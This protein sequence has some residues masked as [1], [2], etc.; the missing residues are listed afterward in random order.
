MKGLQTKLKQITKD[1]TKA[2]ISVGI[3]EPDN[4]ISIGNHAL[5]FNATGDF[6][7]GIP[8]RRSVLFWGESGTGKSMLAGTI[9]KNAQDKGYFV[10]YIDTEQAIHTKYLEKIGVKI[11]DDHFYATRISTITELTK[12]FS[13][14]LKAFDEDDKVCYIIDSLSN[15]ETE[16]GEDDFEKGVVKGDMGQLAKQLKKFMKNANNK[17]GDR[18]NFLICTAHAYQNQTPM[19]GEGL[20][21]TSGGKGFIYLP[22]ISF[23]LTKLKLKDEK[24]AKKITGIRLTAEVT[25]SRFTQVGLKSQL[26]VPYESGID[27]LD[28][29]FDIALEHGIVHKVSQG[30][31]GFPDPETGELVKF[32]KTN[33]STYAP[34]LL[35]LENECV[36]IEQ[37]EDEE[38]ED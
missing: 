16:T 29:L 27:P 22:S 34:Q 30:W 36:I 17:I 12:N 23:L 28:G 33:F 3:S 6:T 31:Y 32:Q 8:N 11:D 7:R 1:L 4:Y 9:A 10:V 24:D 2:G 35:D 37:P 38:D 21:L 25:K 15:L 19:N 14:M 20:W 13:S 26:E 5:N 18:D